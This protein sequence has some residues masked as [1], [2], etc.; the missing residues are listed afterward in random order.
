MNHHAAPDFWL[1]YRS[2]PQDI[3]KLADQAYERLKQN[4]RHPSLRFKRVGRFWSARVGAHY[5][6]VAVEAADGFVWFWVGTHAEYNKL[7]G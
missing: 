2:L 3:R 7:L 4:P 5:R 6:A 1:C